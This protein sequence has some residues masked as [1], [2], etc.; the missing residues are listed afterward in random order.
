MN[1]KV[2]K[3]SFALGPRVPVL[4]ST[5]YAYLYTWSEVDSGTLKHLFVMKPGKA[6][7]TYH[8]IPTAGCPVK[9]PP[10]F[11]LVYF[12]E[13]VETQIQSTTLLTKVA[14][15]GC[16]LLFLLERK[17]ETSASV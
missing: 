1:T 14:A 9:M 5:V 4:G 16:L 15:H 6:E 2:K 8:Y 7:G 11:I 13:E 3:S 10:R 17:Q 12:K